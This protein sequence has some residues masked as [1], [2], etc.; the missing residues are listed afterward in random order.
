[1]DNEELKKRFPFLKNVDLED[2]KQKKK[3]GMI[4]ILIAMGLLVLVLAIMS[5]AKQKAAQAPPVDV[6]AVSQ[7][8]TSSSPADKDG[9]KQKIELLEIPQGE[10]SNEDAVLSSTNMISARERQ[11]SS[12]GASLKDLYGQAEYGDDPLADPLETNQG[13]VYSSSS[14][15]LEEIKRMYNTPGATA[16]ATASK[17]G[18]QA[19]ETASSTATPK[20]KTINRGGAP[21]STTPPSQTSHGMVDPYAPAHSSNPP[22]RVTTQTSREDY[23]G[24][25]SN[26]A[27]SNSRDVADTVKAAPK[28]VRKSGGISSLDDWGSVD[29]IGG[30]DEEDQYVT[31]DA[32]K[33]VKVMFVREQKIT[34]GQRVFLRLLDDIAADGI[35]IPKNTHLSAQCTIGERLQIKVNNIEI[36]GK[37][38][39]LGYT[40]FDNDGNEG[41]HCPESTNKQQ[42]QQ[43]TNTAMNI[44][45]SLLQSR[46]TGIAGQIVSSGTSIIRSSTG[47]VTAQVNAGYTFFLLKDDY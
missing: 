15:N 46:I 19:N 35:L 5:S 44:G 43:G 12:R 2:P 33:P 36:N 29:G 21:S 24:F 42:V 13:K 37:I 6:N 8:Q 7:Q 23:E 45:Q 47:K 4:L 20:K 11:R 16:A 34:S 9:K 31:V 3:I 40:A 18:T 10:N 26:A 38:I 30:L 25:P 22:S 41:L 27:P 1:M 17:E 14:S 32:S 39:N 28:T